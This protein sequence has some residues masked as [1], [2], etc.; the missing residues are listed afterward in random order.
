MNKDFRL[1]FNRESMSGSHR[2]QTH[3]RNVTVSMV[4]E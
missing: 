3:S 2:N 4:G 1:E